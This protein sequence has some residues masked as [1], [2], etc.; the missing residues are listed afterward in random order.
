MGTNGENFSRPGDSGAWM[1]DE[2]G[3]L[4]GIVIGGADMDG[5]SYFTP[6][7]EVVEDIERRLGCKVHLSEVLEVTDDD[8]T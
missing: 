4:G 5:I 2:M 1:T 8:E 6:I 7:D 3:A